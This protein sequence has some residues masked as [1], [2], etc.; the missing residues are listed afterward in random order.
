MEYT[1]SKGG[2]IKNHLGRMQF[3]DTADGCKVVY[4]IV[5]DGRIPLTGGIIANGLQTGIRKGLAKL[6]R[7]LAAGKA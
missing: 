6:A 7:D 5:F 2:P 4:R 1:V 3:S